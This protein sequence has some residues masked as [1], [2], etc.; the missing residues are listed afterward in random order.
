LSGVVPR[1]ARVEWVKV[2]T[3]CHIGNG[4]GYREGVDSGADGHY[5]RYIS[6]FGEAEVV[7]FLKLFEDS[8][9]TVDFGATKADR[10][11]RALA[12]ALRQKTKNIHVQRAIDVLLA[13]PEGT[14]RKLSIVTKFREAM[15]SLPKPS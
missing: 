3:K 8:D 4:H 9:L 14:L 12:T 6:G 1:A 15:K 13:Q 7:Q 11:A 2:I 10:R 5:Q